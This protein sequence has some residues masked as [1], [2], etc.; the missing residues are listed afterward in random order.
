MPKTEI[1][2]N[3]T[4]KQVIFQIRYPNLFYIESKI[5]DIQLE[6]MEMF[7]ETELIFRRHLII[8]TPGSSSQPPEYEKEEA[9]T[10]KIWN[11]KN[12]RGF[13]LNIASDSL[14]ITSSLHKTYDKDGEDKFRE[15][16]KHVVDTF[17]SFVKIPVISRIGFRYI[18]ECPLPRRDN[19]TFNKLFNSCFPV[20]RFPVENTTEMD[21]K[22]VIKSGEY[23]LRYVESLQTGGDKHFLIMDFDGFA[24]N[25]KTTDYL[26][27][28]DALHKMIVDEYFRSLKEPFIEY[29][30]GNNDLG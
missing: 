29:M 14:S 5:G 24:N 23:L 15:V 10:K 1:F 13:E 22:T 17:L 9:D 16:I 8:A 4:V 12:E 25:I 30:R 27:T 28:T 21:F 3:S 26:K 19:D 6:L 18:D 11:F 7:P 20:T 2:S